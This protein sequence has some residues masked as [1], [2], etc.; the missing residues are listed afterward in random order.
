MM[1]YDLQAH[2]GA[3]ILGY[4]TRR[5]LLLDLDSV[6]QTKAEMLIKTIF[7]EYKTVGNALIVCS[8]LK[9]RQTTITYRPLQHPELRQTASSYHIIFDNNIGYNT[10]CK[11]ISALAALQ[12]LNKDY[13]K[14]REFRG[15]MTLRISPTI[16]TQGIK[17]I[18]YPVKLLINPY[19]K[20][21]DGN[22]EYYLKLLRSAGLLFS[23]RQ[24]H[25]NSLNSTSDKKPNKLNII[26]I[27]TRLQNTLQRIKKTFQKQQNSNNKNSLCTDIGGYS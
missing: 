23:E 27:T 14:I 13:E 6:T 21:S 3:P 22:I 9:E 12:V 16:T 15:D 20:K 7:Q 25:S 4:T 1:C 24:Q 17:H 8:T 5:H 10:C 11:I 19:T 2:N 18:P 26:R